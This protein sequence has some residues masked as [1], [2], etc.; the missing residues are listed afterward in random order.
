MVFEPITPP[1]NG[2]NLGVVK[3]TIQDRTSRGRVA[4]ESVSV[5]QWPV[6]GHDSGAVFISAHDDLKKSS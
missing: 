4:Q 1:G 2:N 5:L 6:A 3:E